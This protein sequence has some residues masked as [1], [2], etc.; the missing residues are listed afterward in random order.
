VEFIRAAPNI[1]NGLGDPGLWFAIEHINVVGNSFGWPDS[2]LLEQGVSGFRFHG[3]IITYRA[4]MAR[5]T[6]R[7]LFY[8][9]STCDGV[10]GQVFPLAIR[11][12]LPNFC[13]LN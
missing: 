5:T 1:P 3:R 8:C 2:G 9:K 6:S 7:L 4:E 13:Y 10:F 12:G 11:I